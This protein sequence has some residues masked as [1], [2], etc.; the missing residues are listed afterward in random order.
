MFLYSHIL[1]IKYLL[2]A[3][4][5]PVNDCEDKNDKM[6]LALHSFL[7]LVHMDV[8]VCRKTIK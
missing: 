3:F 1:F 8:G 6:S 2:T 5:V 4:Y 7:Y